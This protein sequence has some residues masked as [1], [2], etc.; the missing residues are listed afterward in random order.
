MSV[1]RLLKAQDAQ[2]HVFP[3]AT[4]L[5]Y[6]HHVAAPVLVFEQAAHLADSVMR[7]V[8]GPAADPGLLIPT[9]AHKEERH[10]G[11]GAYLSLQ[12][13]TQKVIFDLLVKYDYIVLHSSC[14][15]L[16]EPVAMEE[17]PPV[18]SENFSSA[19][20]YGTKVP[21]QK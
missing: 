4:F 21:L 3:Q 16:W 9:A 19:A 13:S 14:Q 7:A 2:L 5:P 15:A 12:H 18:P 8:L 10:A 17:W 11:T 20:S 6:L 1:P